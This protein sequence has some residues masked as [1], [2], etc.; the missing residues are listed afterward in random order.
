MVVFCFVYLAILYCICFCL[1]AHG[2]LWLYALIYHIKKCILIL[3]DSVGAKLLT[4]LE[5]VSGFL[6]FS[7]Y[8][9]S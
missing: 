9:E 5:A 2:P 3:V 7:L 4:D 6:I 8:T 1:Y